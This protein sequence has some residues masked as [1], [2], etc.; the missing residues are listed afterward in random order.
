MEILSDVHTVPLEKSNFVRPLR[1]LFK[2]V[3]YIYILHHLN[4]LN[5]NQQSGNDR[6]E[7]IE[8]GTW[9]KCTRGIL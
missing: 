8:Y 4:F 3:N 7:R 2:Q 9:L 1:M 5:L 6:M